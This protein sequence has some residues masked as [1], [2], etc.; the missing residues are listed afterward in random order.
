MSVTSRQNKL[1]VA[2]DWKKIYQSFR[3][4]DFQ[5]YDFEN[6]RRTMI[7]YIRTNY[8]E[9]FN[10]YVESSEYLALID[11]IAFLG[12]SVAFRVD[13]NARD[14][15]LE[16]SERRESILRLARLISYNAKRNISARGLLKITTISTTENVI[17]SNGRNVS[18]QV[19]AWND[20]SNSNWYDQFIKVMNAALPTTQQFG[21]PAD[22]ATIYDIPTEQYRFNSSNTSVPV[23]GFT[24]T[25]AGRPMNFEISS[26]TFSGQNYIYEEPP[27]A[28]NTLACI[29]RDDGRGA[30]SSN[31]GFFLNFVQGTLN[32]GTF[33]ITQPSSNESVDVDADNI[34]NTDVWLYKL[35]QSGIEDT[36]WTP[37]S[38]FEANN[39]IYNSV[40]KNIRS[41]YAVITRSGD[42]ISLQFSDGTFGDLPVGVFRT[43]YR[44]SNGLNYSIN[45]KDI[46]SV[47][48]SVP[49]ISAV[50]QVE[51]LSLTLGLQTTVSNATTTESNASIKANAPATYYTQNRMITGED[52][53][54]SPLAVTNAVAKVKS[55]N[56][57]ASGISRYFDLVD[58]TGKYS[59][60]RLFADDGVLYTEYYT[61]QARFSYLSRTDIEG[62]IYNTIFDILKKENL[63]NFYYSKFNVSLATGLSLNWH[64]VTKDSNASTGHVASPDGTTYKVGSYTSTELKYL[65]VG[66]LI[67]FTA[68]VNTYFNTKNSNELVAIPA[69]GI[70]SGGTATLWAEVVSV[71]DD[72]TAANT[73]VLNTGFGPIT[74]N[75]NIPTAAA[76]EY[77]I[78]RWRTSIDSSVITTMVDLIS[79]NKP[80]GLRYDASTQTWK[81][82]FEYNLNTYSKFSLGKQGDT[83]N[84]HQDASWMLL[85]TT[86]NEYYTVT[87]REQRYIFESNGQISF[88]YDNVNKIYDS[89]TNSIIKDCIKILPINSQ[90]GS[91]VPFTISQDWDIVSGFKGLDGYI[92]MKKIVVS[93]AD[94]DNNGIVDDPDLFLNIVAPPAITETNI[95]VLSQK[96]IVLEK[97]NITAGQDD[98][99]YV[100][101]I[102][103]GAVKIR[104]SKAD[105]LGSVNQFTNGQYFYFID[106]DTVAKLNTTLGTLT[107]SLDY[108]VYLGRDQLKFQ[109]D[110]SADYTSRIDPGTSNIIDVFVLT[111][112]Y[113]TNF[114]QWL[115][116]ANALK[117]L[118]PGSDELYD[119][120]APSLNTIK[121][122]SDE[123]VYH[124]VTYKILFGATAAPELQ[125]SFKVVKNSSQVISDNDIKARIIIAIN[126]FFT[127]DNWDFGDTFY[128]SELSSY[129]MTQLSPDIS[130][131]VIVPR[132]GGLNFGNLFEIKSASDELFINGATVSDIEIISGITQGAI[133]ALPGT[134]TDSSV[135]AQQTITSSTYGASNG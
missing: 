98:Y 68:P 56:R 90:P 77:I 7:D 2:E 25:V 16:L 110:H 107:A 61:D 27:R 32:T 102:E 97:Y 87:S 92:D 125:A 106:T 76:I 78:P 122:I 114:R 69:S 13:L 64:R 54:I 103:T 40:N 85:F 26:T 115:L 113:D 48:I 126:Q 96:Y 124:P 29:Y 44:I 104:L 23:F 42:Q 31:S 86:D 99:R 109:Y 73:G 12:Q 49:Y 67:K 101:A 72:G 19:I 28:G 116:G 79:S 70:P 128:F 81:I 74:L 129:V 21:N 4:A 15:F 43:Y 52:Y 66:S 37:V 10:D 133:K 41:I 18:G 119:T 65:T 80:F 84:E 88:Y 36:L 34:N 38:N 11:L 111:K 55:V 46:R 135:L 89:R 20:S 108:K 33:S 120:L 118:P 3:N 51:T 57:T 24:K 60:T 105:V 14:N 6:L 94:S 132:F 45:P 59:S 130:S 39:V 9:D 121:S 5:S 30:G 50:G 134:A 75:R 112:I 100:N 123:V 8:P 22:S 35:G 131:F 17:D 62:T 82:I 47:S 91:T 95:N 93:F 53:N 127:V 63:R 83:S 1:L 71:V 58:P 117:P